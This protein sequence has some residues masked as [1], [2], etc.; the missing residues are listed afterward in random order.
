V[1]PTSPHDRL[2]HFTFRHPAHVAGWLA[3]AL[4]N[5][6]AHAIDWTSLIPASERLLGARLRPHL[7][8]L[9]FAAR[10]RD[11]DHWLLLLVEHKAYPDHGVHDQLLRYT[12][13]LRR[14]AAHGE[15]VPFCVPVLLQHGGNVPT[16]RDHAVVLEPEGVRQAL[17]A[18]QPQL[19]FV[20]DDLTDCDELDLRRP[21]MTPLAQ[22]TLLC[23][24][25]LPRCDGNEALAAIARWADLLQ[26]V[27]NAPAPP[28]GDDAVDAIGWYL[29]DVT[30]VGLDDLQ[31]AFQQHLN[32]YRSPIMTTAERIRQEGVAQGITQG[33]T[34]GL[35]RGQTKT[36]LRQMH[37]RFGP[38]PDAVVARIQTA[39]EAELDRL[40]DS[41]L[42][43]DS[44]DGLLA[45]PS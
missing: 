43:V 27:E 11:H 4:P 2:F 21:G 15:L 10:L 45:D 36:L 9:V 44:L 28:L 18:M 6:V 5:P 1:T 7:A 42:D 13:H 17:V 22:L 29:L 32:R 40:T 12:V 8:D 39:S 30:D 24:E 14:L 34:Q 38:L 41:I 26:A 35:S 31:M 33:I 20:V 23:L 3:H 16:Q 25:C 37:K 19:A